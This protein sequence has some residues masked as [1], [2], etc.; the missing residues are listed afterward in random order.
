MDEVV[1]EDRYPTGWPAPL[2]DLRR[3]VPIAQT[4][5]VGG[6]VLMLLSIN[7]TGRHR[8]RG[9]AAVHGG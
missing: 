6:V 4:V 2:R 3:I 9:R 1:G 8:E 7:G 5:E